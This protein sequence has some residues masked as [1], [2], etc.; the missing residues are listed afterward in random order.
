MTP[1]LM[2]H[3]AMSTINTAA[4]PTQFTTA[5]PPKLVKKIL[6]LEFI[7]MAELVSNAWQHGAESSPGCCSHS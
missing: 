6:D 4:L 5:L 3:T 7:D 2:G 1:G